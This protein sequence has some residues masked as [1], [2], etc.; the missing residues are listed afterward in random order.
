ML[1]LCVFFAAEARLRR[2]TSPKD[3][4]RVH[5]F[6][7]FDTFG[8]ASSADILGLKHFVNNYRGTSVFAAIRLVFGVHLH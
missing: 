1:T 8:M 6:D 2:I 3:P 7:G 4:R 5:P